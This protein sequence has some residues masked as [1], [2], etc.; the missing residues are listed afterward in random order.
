MIYDIVHRNTPDK[1]YL[2]DVSSSEGNEIAE[3]PRTRH[4]K[5]SPKEKEKERK[6]SQPVSQASRAFFLLCHA[7]S[8]TMK[9]SQQTNTNTQ[10]ELNDL[11]ILKLI[12]I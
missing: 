9:K 2:T 1:I 7:K 6:V 3:T 4:S 12:T 8:L 5:R 10:A 11:I